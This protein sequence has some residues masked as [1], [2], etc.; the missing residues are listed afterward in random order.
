MKAIQEILC[1]M[2]KT[3]CWF[4]TICFRFKDHKS[5]ISGLRS[6]NL[7]SKTF[8]PLILIIFC[9]IWLLVIFSNVLYSQER[10]IKF[11]NIGIEE[12]LSQA[13]IHCIWQDSKGFIWIGTESGVNR[14]DGY[15]FIVYTPDIRNPESLSNNWVYSI[16]EDHLG[17]I[18]IGTDGGLNRF[19]REKEIF[20]RYLHDPEKPN[21]LSNNKVFTIFEDKSGSLWIGTDNGLNKFDRKD[22]SFKRYQFDPENPQSLSDNHI[23]AILEDASGTL[24]VGTDNGLNRFNRKEEAWFRFQSDPKDRNSLSHNSI[25]SICEDS[26]DM[27][28]I[29]TNRGLN[30]FDPTTG[31]FMQ[32]QHIANDSKSLSDDWIHVVY[33]DRLGMLWIGTNEGGLNRFEREKGEFICYK[34]DPNN[35][36]SLSSDRIYSICEDRSGV[37]WIGTYGG[38]ICKFDR[39]PRKFRCFTHD[40]ENPYSLSHMFVRSFYEDQSG[41]LW[42]GTDGGG[43]NKYDQGKDQFI[44]YRHNPRNPTSLSNDSVFSIV[45]DSSGIFWIGTYGGGLN[46]FDPN[47]GKFTSYRHSPIDPN[48][49]S[50]DRI[51]VIYEGQPGVLWI[52]TDGGGLN[53][54]ETGKGIFTRYRH[55]PSDP[56][57]LSNDRIRSILKSRSGAMWIATFG[58]GLNKFDPEKGQFFH[59]RFDPDDPNSLSNDY[60]MALYED[61][62]GILWIGSNGEGLIRFDSQRETF[63][64]YAES[65]GLAGSAVYGI[66]EDDEGN[67]WIS[68]NN[69]LSKFNPQT[70]TFRNYD[71]NDGLQSN[72][73]NGGSRYKSPK[74]EMFFGG[75][76]GFNRFYPETI[77]DN[78]YIPS[79]VIT[80]FR[81]FNKVVPIQEGEDRKS[82]LTK[83]ITETDEIE[84]SYRDNMLSF[85]F[86]ALHYVFPDK[87]EY[88]YRMEGFDKNWI[89]TSAAHRFATY[90]NLNPGEYTFRVKA[91][92]NDG[93]WN[94]EG[95][96][97]NIKIIPAFWQTWWFRSFVLT[98]IIL[99]I[100]MVYEVRTH[101]IKEQSKRLEKRVEE[102][103]SELNIANKE[104]QEQITERKRAEEILRESEEK[105]RN[106][107]NN[108][109][110]GC[111]I[112]ESKN[113][114]D[115][116]LVEFNSA[117]EKMDNLNRKEMIGKS[118][119]ELFPEAF[120]STAIAEIFKR[121]W[122]TGKP[123]R[124]PE[125]F[126]EIGGM[127]VWRDNFFYKLS[128]GEIIVIYEDITERKRVEAQLSESLKE[129]EV[130][131]KEIHHRV[132]NNMQIIS[133]L[134]RLQ[135]W[136][137]K[138][139]KMREMF[140]VSQSR[141]RS[142]AL[143]HK[144]LYQSQDLARI[145]F[146]DYIKSLTNSLVS[147]YRVG[148]EPITFKLD[149]KKV[150][151]DI[152]TAI[153][154]GLIINELVT[155]SLKYAFPEQR[156]WGETDNS[157][158]EIFLSLHSYKGRVSLIVRDNGMGL[159][160]DFNFRKTESMGLQLVNDLVAQLDG[161]IE[162]QEEGGT[163]FKITFNVQE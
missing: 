67:L 138:N 47:S 136:H 159:P 62:S 21:S 30:R 53:K 22:E 146:Y 75:I 117:S 32:Y 64:N 150:Y 73:F 5:Q 125:S 28:W 43:L 23:H 152:N 66:L 90:T 51:R 48:T 120:E 19:N 149:I 107:Y 39:E 96:S 27:L 99:L 2:E 154:L 4:M 81:I 129:K 36:Y 103:T 89:Y 92:N 37:I 105:F 91:S 56:N 50:D 61:R 70:E 131:L 10:Q 35:P 124:Y 16:Y 52:G 119:F 55:D 40:P 63:S 93:I 83:S 113:G 72:E 151:F 41:T 110:S 57:S 132:K 15:D 82:P 6:R 94:E 88:A 20:T 74:G 9:S 7:S 156:A 97:L 34:A 123:E 3:I 158:G 60:I 134:L 161:T 115:F 17:N 106:L 140:E 126:Y 86:A 130:L 118:V 148:L 44:H 46:R 112:Y 157:K 42:V 25:N 104:L 58:G 122:K 8:I 137:I 18:W 127:K 68:T 114:E 121:V 98:A 14:Y 65:E 29:G 101:A 26:L 133:S 85:E 49:L 77:K 141:I 162:L 31:K 135:S 80:N 33:Q 79:V 111:T 13:S 84:L 45:K 71:V 24:W 128:T 59:Y 95:T 142:M 76:N 109:S 116:I 145:D 12:G 160:K 144:K 87:N 163:S 1:I 78:P 153:P 69:G 11:E 54:F 102:R 38:G 100:L 108:M 155:N 147:T 139:K 143:I